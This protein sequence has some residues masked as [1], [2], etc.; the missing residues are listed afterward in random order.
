MFLKCFD[1]FFSS[2]VFTT[3]NVEIEIAVPLNLDFKNLEVGQPCKNLGSP[4]G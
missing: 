3:L 1:V 2:A 4:L